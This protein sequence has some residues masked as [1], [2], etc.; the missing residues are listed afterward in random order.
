MFE[1]LRQL[2]HFATRD[3]QVQKRLEILRRHTPIPIIWLFGKTQSGKTSLIKFLTG[4]E[5]AEIGHGFKPCTR[6]SHRYNFP[7][8]EA[9]LLTFLD[10]RGMDE[11][12]YNPDEDLEQFDN[13]AHVVIVTI[14]A[15]DHAQGSML[16]HLRRIRG[17]R[18]IRPV[19]LVVTCLHEA[20]PQ[21]QHVEPYPFGTGADESRAPAELRWSL[22]EQYRR[23]D[24]LFDKAVPVDITRP[25]DGFVNSNYGGDEL[26]TALL[27]SL[28]DAYRQTFLTLEDIKRT[29]SDLYA[30]QALPRI[31]G[32]SSLAATAGALPV[33]WLDLLIL[34]AI[35]SRMI[36]HL[37][38]FYGQPLTAARFMEVVSTLG[39]G[40]LI[41]QASRE[42]AK[43]IPYAGSVAGGVLAGAST[44]ALGK[45][46]CYYYRAVHQGHVPKAEE[47]RRY[48]Q[49]QL[50]LAEKSWSSVG[51]KE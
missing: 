13:L 36:F 27:G 21:K 44:F 49:E 10:T 35:Q 12:G 2:M 22:E 42:V 25:E 30:R 14:K 43:L 16:D 3:E 6:F 37:A 15:L 41:R 5:E 17:A 33:P 11:P 38:K 51:K 47:L 40:I 1:K 8:S 19:I 32:Y 23:F 34:P 4:A 24:G 18:P 28:P 20:Y 26:K 29:L 31:A 45:A 7:T 39:V 9:P 48:Y 46:F 50:T